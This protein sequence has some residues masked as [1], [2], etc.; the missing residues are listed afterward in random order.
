MKTCADTPGWKNQYGIG[1]AGYETEG[2]C[3]DGKVVLGHEWAVGSKFGSP[4]KHCC[5]CG[6]PIMCVAVDRTLSKASQAYM[7]G[8]LK[9]AGVNPC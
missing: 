3:A 7:E 9:K 8:L 2:H 5:V 4:E 6:S 1:C